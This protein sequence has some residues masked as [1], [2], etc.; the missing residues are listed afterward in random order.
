M[1][2]RDSRNSDSGRERQLPA[3]RP[4]RGLEPVDALTLYMSELRNYAPIS[5]EEEHLLAT[6]WVEQG[7]QEPLGGFDPAVEEDR[8]DDRLDHRGRERLGEGRLPEHALAEDEVSLEFE[9]PG[10]LGARPSR[11]RGRLD[12]G[13]VAFEQ[14]GIE[15]KDPLAGNHAENRVA[16][17]LHPLV[18]VEAMGRDRGVDKRSLEQRDIREVIPHDRFDLFDD[19]AFHRGDSSIGPGARVEEPKDRPRRLETRPGMPLISSGAGLE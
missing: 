13:H 5:R 3:P 11:D 19:F 8:P 1:T 2:A 16:E 7:D 9:R 18:A 4:E 14:C 12:L 15:I 6:R 17:E 10:D